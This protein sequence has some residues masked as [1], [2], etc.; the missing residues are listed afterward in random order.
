M[1]NERAPYLVEGPTT[2]TFSRTGPPIARHPECPDVMYF[3]S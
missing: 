2:Q 3:A 1:A